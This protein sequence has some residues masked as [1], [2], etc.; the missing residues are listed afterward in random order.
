MVIGA[1]LPGSPAALLPPVVSTPA[2]RTADPVIVTAA[3]LPPPSPPE[4]GA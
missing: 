1:E 2:V 4:L 3:A